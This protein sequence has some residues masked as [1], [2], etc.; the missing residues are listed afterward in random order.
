MVTAFTKIRR[1]QRLILVAGNP[2]SNR[3]LSIVKTLVKSLKAVP[4][5]V[6]FPRNIQITNFYGLAGC[7]QK[8]VSL[9]LLQ[10]LA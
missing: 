2:S 1:L 9:K 8:T 3:V 7:T 6:G 4:I 10:I 5:S